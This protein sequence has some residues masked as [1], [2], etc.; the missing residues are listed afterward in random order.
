MW[1][2]VQRKNLTE[3]RAGWALPGSDEQLH[4]DGVE[5]VSFDR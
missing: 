3:I 1:M 5:D 2:R 4:A